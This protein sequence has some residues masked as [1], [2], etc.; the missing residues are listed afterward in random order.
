MTDEQMVDTFFVY[1]HLPDKLQDIS[2]TFCHLAREI[3]REYPANDER[4]V[5]L[6][7]LLEAKD[8][9]VRCFV[10]DDKHGPVTF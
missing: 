7:K 4:T 2:M 10:F 6:R 9:A 5:T 3:V 8:A 1:K